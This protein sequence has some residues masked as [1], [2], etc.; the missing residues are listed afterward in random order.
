MKN[1]N[2][3]SRIVTD[4]YVDLGHLARSLSRHVVQLQVHDQP[5]RGVHAEVMKA[6]ERHPLKSTKTFT[7]TGLFQILP[8]L[9]NILGASH[10]E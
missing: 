2:F 5:S 9:N 7:S 4:I 8:Y 6:R 10:P 3:V 1:L